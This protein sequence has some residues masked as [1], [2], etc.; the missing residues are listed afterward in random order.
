VQPVRTVREE[1]S[2]WSIPE[3]VEEGLDSCQVECQN[4]ILL[5]EEVKTLTSE[6]DLLPTPLVVVLGDSVEV[7][8]AEEA[9]EEAVRHSPLGFSSQEWRVL[10][11]LGGYSGGGAGQAGFLP[12]GNGGSYFF[13]PRNVPGGAVASSLEHLG[14]GKIY[15]FGPY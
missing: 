5:L 15:I 10:T 13:S 8:R 14:G 3:S 7:V 9:V 2:R 1:A 6:V 11:Q 12:G 4:Q